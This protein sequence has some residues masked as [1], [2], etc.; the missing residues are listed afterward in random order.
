MA[1]A[2]SEQLDALL[3]FVCGALTL[4]VP[5][6]LAFLIGGLGG[7]ARVARAAR[8]ALLGVAVVVLLAVAGGYGMLAGA[9]LVPG[10][11]GRPD[12]GLADITGM[13]G[14]ARA[15]SL[16]AVCGVG[17]AV[18]GVALASRITTRAWIVF[19]VLWSV[20]VLFP[21][22]YA[23]FAL[24]D[25]W[26]VAG[27]GVVDFGGILP[28]GVAAGGGAAGVVLACGRREHQVEGRRSLPL[29]AIGGALLWL[30]WL[31]LATGSEGALDDFTA[32]IAMNA[33]LASAGG[34][35]MWL[36]VDRV[37]LRRPTVSSGLLGAFAGLVAATPA[38]GVLTLGWS[39]LL[40]ALAALACATMVDLAARARFGPALTLCVTVSVG[41]LVG[42]LYV[43]LFASGGG[44]VESGNFDLFIGQGIAGLV[45]LLYSAAVSALIALGLRFT[46]GLTR[47]RGR[48]GGTGGVASQGVRPGAVGYPSGRDERSPTLDSPETAGSPR[49][50]APAGRDS[51]HAAR[52]PRARR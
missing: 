33:F 29:V 17:V 8:F 49:P 7:G 24:D 37:L 51:D 39:L 23:V 34:C 31:G 40:G 46:I 14:L 42:L 11:V 19:C 6:G 13:Y 21:V 25:G 28:I 18:V 5:P 48:G 9:P 45:V 26:A 10:V 32:L 38:S 27:L 41:G 47:T 3:L 35:L 30:G 12:P 22:G 2:T 52:D 15:G 36:L 50:A 20:L 4:L 16:I 1:N 43:G 44:M